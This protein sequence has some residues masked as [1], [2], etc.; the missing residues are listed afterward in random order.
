[1]EARLAGGLYRELSNGRPLEM[2]AIV[3]LAQGRLVATHYGLYNT[4]SGMA[5]AL[6]NLLT[7][8]AVGATQHTRL[9]ALPWAGLAAVGAVSALA[10][11]RL[12]R[13]GQLALPLPTPALATPR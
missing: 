6:G 11:R 4:L 7:G 9:A 8:A 2:D 13:R 3:T 5:I 10:V 12:A 1:M